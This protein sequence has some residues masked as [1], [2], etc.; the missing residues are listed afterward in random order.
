MKKK[1]RILFAIESLHLGGA[2]KSL[3]TLLSNLDFS[4]VEADLLIFSRGGV[5]EKLVPS[6]VNVIGGNYPSF[7]LGRRVL[8]KLGKKI[9]YGDLHEAQLFWKIIKSRVARLNK[10]YDVAIAYNQQFVSYFVAS[11]VRADRK[12]AWMNTLYGKARYNPDFDWPYFN[13]LDAVVAVSPEAL[14][15]LDLAFSRRNYPLKTLMIKDIIETQTIEK[16]S[17]DKAPITFLTDVINLVTVCR[18]DASKGLYLALGAAEILKSRG[19]QFRWYIIGEGPER[20]GLE[21]VLKSK[22]LTEYVFLPGGT[23]NPYPY[24]RSCDIYVQTSLVEGLGMTV[25]E[26]VVLRK[27]VVCTNFS[28]AS[29]IVA[30]QDILTDFTP[31]SIAD[32][33]ATFI[34]DPGKMIRSGG[35]SKRIDAD[36]TVSLE[37]FYS[38]LS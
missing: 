23:A 30:D 35:S 15:E 3:V 36:K 20:A 17:L 7:S 10:E 32:G 26:A 18:L 5:F 34:D 28:T 25:I 12:Y 8:Y 22:G 11:C 14:A 33:V 13:K 9:R 27:P 4:V 31:Q 29:S 19:Y 16:Q 37:K 6:Q 1:I 38:L 2:E 24:M 21:L